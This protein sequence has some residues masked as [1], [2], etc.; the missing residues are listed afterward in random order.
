[1]YKFLSRLMF[2]LLLALVA[3]PAQTQHYVALTWNASPTTGVHY[4]VYRATGVVTAS[5]VKI[6]TADVLTTSYSDYAG[7]AGTT[8]FYEVTAI[9]NTTTTCS[10]SVT[11][12]ESTPSAPSAG[13]T[14]L[15]SPQAPI[16]TPGA[17]AH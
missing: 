12:G 17:T 10:A 8:Y 4:N 7:V 6:N 14:F 11:P 16:G 5:F 9:C 3:L 2:S 15:G 1:M 13:V